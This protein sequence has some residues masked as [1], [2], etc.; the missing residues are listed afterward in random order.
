MLKSRKLIVWCC[1]LASG[2]IF[3]GTV[4]SQSLMGAT[5]LVTIP[6][7]RMQQDGTISIGASYFDRKHQEYFEGTMNIGMAYVNI[8]LLPF[9]ELAMR[10]NR[11][12]PYH[13]EYTVDRAPM[14]R[15]RVLKERKYLPAVVIGI[16]DLASTESW[17]TVH[18]NATYLV[19]AKKVSDFD[20]HFGYAP[21]I[22]KA[23]Y[24][25]LNGVFGGVAYS[26]HKAIN[27]FA[28]YDTRHVNAGV[29]FLLLKHIGI[30]LGTVNFDSWAVGV[31]FKA[32]LQ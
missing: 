26:P 17:G 22:M 20:F 5:G 12:V 25:Q 2:S 24:Y 27:L 6:T 16:H 18:F 11:P 29:Q 7:A 15:F 3:P 13:S 1:L 31:N 14:V 32:C 4:M 30:N 23:L 28:E 19:L 21:E 8:T 10:V 9:L